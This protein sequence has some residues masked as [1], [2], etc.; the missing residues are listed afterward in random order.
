MFYQPQRAYLFLKHSLFLNFHLNND[1]AVT[2]VRGLGWK[3]SAKEIQSFF[4]SQKSP[5]SGSFLYIVETELLCDYRNVAV[6]EQFKRD[7]NQTVPCRQKNFNQLLDEK[8]F[9]EKTI[10]W[11]KIV[12]VSMNLV[13]RKS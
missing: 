5:D 13:E 6:V 2:A 4:L 12:M 7:L 10:D 8:I 9:S 3:F 1:G 11:S